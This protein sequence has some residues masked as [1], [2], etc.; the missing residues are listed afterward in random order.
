MYVGLLLFLIFPNSVINGL[1][2]SKGYRLE[3]VVYAIQYPDDSVTSNARL[4]NQL[5][6]LNLTSMKVST[7]TIPS[8]FLNLGH[9]SYNAYQTN[10]ANPVFVDKNYT[11]LYVLTD[12]IDFSSGRNTQV[13]TLDLATLEYSKV[14]E[15]RQSDS[16]Y[17]VCTATYYLEREN[18]MMCFGFNSANLQLSTLTASYF[19]VSEMSYPVSGFVAKDR[20]KMYL[21]GLRN[22]LVVYDYA[23]K[24]HLQT[25]TL[26][27]YD[28]DSVR[29]AYFEADS[30]MM[31]YTTYSEVYEY[32]LA[33]N[34]VRK[35]IEAF[36]HTSFMQPVTFDDMLY[37]TIYPGNAHIV[38][39]PL[40]ISTYLSIYSN[41]NYLLLTPKL[42][43]FSQSQQHCVLNELLPCEIGN[44]RTPGQTACL[45]C[46]ANTYADKPGSINCTACTQCTEEHYVSSAC[47]GTND[48]TCVHCSDLCQPGFYE[49]V[50]CTNE[51]NRI[52]MPCPV[53]FYCTDKR[54]ECSSCAPGQYVS[55]ECDSTTN[56][57]C[58]EC[59]YGYLCADGVRVSD[60]KTCTNGT[61]VSKKC[62]IASDTEC[63]ACA[64]SS[65]P[66]NSYFTGPGT[67]FYN[68][69]W[70]CN[71]GYEKTG[72][73][74][75]LQTTTS[76]AEVTSFTSSLLSTFSF[77][78]TSPL[79]TTNKSMLAPNNTVSAPNTFIVGTTT[80]LPL[81]I[82]ADIEVKAIFMMVC[83]N[84]SFFVSAFCDDMRAY[85]PGTIFDCS[86]LSL[87]GVL[88]PS[89]VCPCVN[90]SAV[91]RLLR[92]QGHSNLVVRATHNKQS[93]PVV[94]LTNPNFA[95]YTY[96]VGVSVSS[97]V[98]KEEMT[99]LYVLAGILFFL[100]LSFVLMF[101]CFYCIPRSFWEW[102]DDWK[103][104]C[105]DCWRQ[106]RSEQ[107]SDVH[108]RIVSSKLNNLIPK[109]FLELKIR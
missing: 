65:K 10:V 46:S 42:N 108:S 22:Q 60:C 21:V 8:G 7:C 44:F 87:D 47:N 96:K 14:F 56:T 54:R 94:N 4:D 20:K 77:Q 100:G 1:Q 86:A 88:C 19:T 98:S 69:P 9:G 13:W 85:N 80:S 5:K 39:T 18:E 90:Q 35:L 32:D 2:C 15:F 84:L 92:A 38:K 82:I 26:P 30:S 27:R 16:Q 57:E 43:K 45:L 67:S 99:A 40:N 95:N 25:H 41:D 78:S 83:M 64:F 37:V 73:L 102:L 6:I 52:C 97:P 34:N 48:A 23:T 49:S 101:V 106:R 71:D 81:P 68:C 93:Q 12:F 51:S 91:R 11:K 58:S 3:S 31:Y 74:C 89:G 70:S 63:L 28:Y 33:T 36:R 109:S 66:S 29:Y 62:T 53:N 59:P 105:N 75:V 107:T 61:Y 104:R 103:L 17:T 24:A 55:G 79:L 76:S 50:H 72:A